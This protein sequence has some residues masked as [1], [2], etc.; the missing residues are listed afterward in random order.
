MRKIDLADLRITDKQKRFVL[1]SLKNNRLT[2]G[3]MTS[4][5]EKKF[6]QMHKAEY[7]IFTN[8]GT[9]A[10]QVALHTLKELGHWKDGDEVI[11][12][13]VTF[14]AT[15]N[16]VLQN[17]LKPVFVDVELNG[18]IDTLLIESAITERTRAII[19]VHL[20]GK[21]ANMDGVMRIEEV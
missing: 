7:G 9:S 17:K 2:Y 21:P 11:V 16:I 1:R 6:S 5:F 4:R 10:L 3:K 14:V 13:A 19:P 15:I 20:L 8:S 18:N 12:P